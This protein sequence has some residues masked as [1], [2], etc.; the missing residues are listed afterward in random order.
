MKRP[1]IADGWD[2]LLIFPIIEQY[3][4]EQKSRDP[5]GRM[6]Y[7]VSTTKILDYINENPTVQK[8][9]IIRIEWCINHSLREFGYRKDSV[10]GRSYS[11]TNIG[12]I[13]P[14]TL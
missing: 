10:A 1:G 12:V 11:L 2:Y 4:L 8:S 5:E 7:R 3:L 9:R 13:V 6:P 14:V